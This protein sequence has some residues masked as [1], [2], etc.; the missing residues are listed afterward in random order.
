M[1]SCLLDTNGFTEMLTR[2][3]RISGRTL[4][5]IQGCSRVLMS[6]VSIYEI[7]QKVR[8]GKWPAMEPYLQ[9]IETIAVN[10]GIEVLPL[11]SGLALRAAMLDWDHRDPFDRMI[12][13][14][15]IQEQVA[16]VSSDAAFEAVGV[17]RVW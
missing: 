1:T 17:E 2:G 16:V 5:F 10:D 13:A 11:T 14:V 6:S 8:L 9:E 3:P 4:E 15:A 12:A 7:G